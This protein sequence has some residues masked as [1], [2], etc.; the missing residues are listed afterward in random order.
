[1]ENTHL[2]LYYTS[3]WTVINQFSVFKLLFPELIK[4]TDGAGLFYTSVKEEKNLDLL[5][6][7]IVHKLY[8]FQFTSPALVVEKDAVFM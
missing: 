2:I 7:Y 5:Y 6:K 8:D 3:D 4:Q 1:M